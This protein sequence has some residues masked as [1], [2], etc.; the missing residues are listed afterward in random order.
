MRLDLLKQCDLLIRKT[1]K[2]WV[3]PAGLAENVDGE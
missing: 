3:P 1:L 2:Q